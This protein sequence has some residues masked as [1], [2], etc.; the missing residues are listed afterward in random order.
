[1]ATKVNINGKLQSRPGVYTLIKSGIQNSPVN[2]DY[3]T[4]CIVDTGIGANWG[5]GKGS[6]SYEFTTIQD[7]RNFVKG[8]PLWDLALPL[9]KPVL[10]TN[11]QGVS[12]LILIQA[13][14]TLAA[15]ISLTFT[16]G[17]LVFTTKDEGVNANGVELSSVLTRGYGATFELKNSLYVLKLWHGS[18]KGT[19]SANSVPYEGITE[20]LSV[21]TL[22]AESPGF[23]DLPSLKLWLD[24]QTNISTGFTVSFT[25]TAS[26]GVFVSGDIAAHTGNT[27]ATGATETYNAAAFTLAV[28]KAKEADCSFFL[29]T[30]SDANAESANNSSLLTDVILQ[31]KYERAMMVAGYATAV[32]LSNSIAIA[33]FFNSDKVI[34]SHGDG[35]TTVRTNQFKIRSS[36]WK[37]ANILG[38]LCGLEPQTPLTLK[39]TGI[40][41]ESNPLDETQQELA[42]ANGVLSTYTDSELGYNVVLQGINSLQNNTYLVNDDGSSFSIAVKRIIAQLNKGLA[43]YLKKKFFGNDTAGPNRNT[44]TEE[45]I[46]AATEFYLQKRTASSLTDDL[47]IRAQNITAVI[48]QDNIFVNYEFVPNFEVNKLIITGT[49]LEK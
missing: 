6:L 44:V 31:G 49:I 30:E 48:T 13:R 9:W 33:K 46:I 26:A 2:L 17:T 4:A 38:R 43:I 47:I 16:N 29:A 1:M 19:D 18:F 3:G 21:P 45:D 22:L 5:G 28:S 20:A 35:L 41:A 25:I 37:A 40:D 39:K 15:T 32:Q 7:F 36:L 42:L 11:L 10:N 24:G 27:L 8:G 12:K 23:T 34:V 14:Q